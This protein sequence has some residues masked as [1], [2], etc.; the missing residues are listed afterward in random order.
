MNRVI[1]YVMLASMFIFCLSACDSKKEQVETTSE[2][3]PVHIPFATA[4][5]SER[6]LRLSDVA[7]S[8]R[9]IPL[10]TTDA[11]LMNRVATGNILKS[12]K[13]WFV[14]SYRELFQFT[15]E[16]KFVRTIGSRGSGPGEYISVL[17]ADI[18]ESLGHVYV[19]S[20]DTKI[21]VYDM[22]TG[23]YLYSR[24]SPSSA[25]RAFLML[26]DSVSVC[27]QYN[28]NGQVQF[29]ILVADAAG[30]TI[31]AFPRSDLFEMRGGYSMVVHFDD[32]RF[33]FRYG[34]KVC[35]KEYYNDTLFV[36]TSD[37]LKPR[38]VFDLGKY[39]MPVE[40][41]PEV[42]DGDKRLFKSA[43]FSY[44]RTQTL[45]TDAW[46]FMPYSYWQIESTIIDDM[47]LLVYNKKQ[48][49]TF[50]V[51]N[52]AIAN[53]LSG[54]PS[55]S[56]CPQTTVASNVAVSLLPAEDI[57]EKAEEDP[58]ILK[59]PRLKELTEDSNPV[60]MVVYLK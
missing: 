56:F 21:N 5:E 7:D 39:S 12:S 26:N 38:Y 55:L 42:L 48:K 44:I 27:Y 1:S 2:G 13:Y 17:C 6:D 41:R 24:K 49:E 50:A 8:V 19:L 16:G 15:D 57:L 4:L 34:D 37:S 35:Y 45:E 29:R 32:D 25:S 28:T 36:V 52:G 20:P 14:P 10:E 11:S 23:T 30:D 43:S 58:A 47:H 53:D 40:H 22:E 51:R 18:D 3:Y 59:H 9:F 60:L 31:Q 46:L 33:M 54:T